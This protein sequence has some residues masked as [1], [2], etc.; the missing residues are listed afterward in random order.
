MEWLG[1]NELEKMWKD[2]DMTYS[3][4]IEPGYNDIGLYDTSSVATDILWY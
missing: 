2:V 3:R 1:N 4:Y